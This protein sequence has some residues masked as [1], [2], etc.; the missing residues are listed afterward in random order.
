LEREKKR[1]YA[2]NPVVPIPVVVE[3]PLL[4]I[5]P[6]NIEPPPP[7]PLPAAEEPPLLAIPP[8][9]KGLFQTGAA[10]NTEGFIGAAPKGEVPKPEKGKI[11]VLSLLLCSCYK[12]LIGYEME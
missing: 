9:P 6:P 11:N 1:I 12:K 8:P 7:P 5:P 3:P 4:L 10:P 2:E